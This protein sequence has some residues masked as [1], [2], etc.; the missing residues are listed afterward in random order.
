LPDKNIFHRAVQSR[1]KSFEGIG[2][3]DTLAPPRPHF[4][5]ARRIDQKRFEPA[6]KKCGVTMRHEQ[7][8]HTILNH[9][10][11]AAVRAANRGLGTSHRFQEGKSESFAAAG[12]CKHIAVGVTCEQLLLREAEEK[13]N[14]V[15]HARVTHKLFEPRAIFPFTNENQ[16]HVRHDPL[17]EA[18][19]PG[20]PMPLCTLQAIR[21]DIACK[22]RGQDGFAA[23]PFL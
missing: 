15:R 14:V 18:P 4:T 6:R 12:Q 8:S 19:S 17:F 7:A 11:R 21:R 20:P 5:G 3:L 23:L 1:L 9:I 10:R 22:T 13:M 16:D 2:S